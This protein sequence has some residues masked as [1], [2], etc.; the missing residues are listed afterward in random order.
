[1]N[2]ENYNKIYQEILNDENNEISANYLL[3]KYEIS[4]DEELINILN[5]IKKNEYISS[6]SEIINKLLKELDDNEEL[7]NIYDIIN[8]KEKVINSDT[9]ETYINDSEV[10]EDSIKNSLKDEEKTKFDL[11]KIKIYLVYLLGFLL[12]IALI[13]YLTNTTNEVE[14][15]KLEADKNIANANISKDLEEKTQN[16]IIEENIEVLE[17]S[18]EEKSVK[19]ETKKIDLEKTSI[20]NEE[21]IDDKLNEDIKINEVNQNNENIELEKSILNEVDQKEEVNNDE[22]TKLNEDSDIEY[23]VEEKL[24]ILMTNSN[25]QDEIKLNSLDDIQKYVKEFT[26]KNGQLSFRSNLYKEND[27][28]FG[29]KIYKITSIYIKFQDE[30]KQ[31]RK[32][33]L[34]K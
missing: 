6:D 29:F 26:Y 14:T 28:L 13:I 15:P 4:H 2:F 17:N 8:V 18:K 3:N 33:F 34:L 30:K 10:E 32:R 5:Q 19:Q 16:N 12:I 22:K 7:L 27:N 25:K 31:I 20:I 9:V 1:M 23:S 24:N 21:K 11:T